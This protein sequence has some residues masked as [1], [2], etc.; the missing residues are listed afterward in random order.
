[1][2]EFLLESR[3][4]NPSSRIW[5][6]KDLQ[7][8]LRQAEKSGDLGLI[9]QTT[10]SNINDVEFAYYTLNYL[11]Y[12]RRA[13]IGLPTTAIRDGNDILN[14][15]ARHRGHPPVWPVGVQTFGIFFHEPDGRW[16]IEFGEPP[17][18]S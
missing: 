12:P 13:L 3:K 16:G 17:P 1:M 10:R 5:I 8:L 6:I 7:S 2:R 14:M 9:F 11:L 18:R 15:I 4:D